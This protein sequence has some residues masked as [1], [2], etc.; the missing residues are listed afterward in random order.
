MIINLTTVHDHVGI[1]ELADLVAV[2][3]RLFFLN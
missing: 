3:K 1:I 2:A